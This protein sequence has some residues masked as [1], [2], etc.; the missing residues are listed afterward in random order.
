MEYKDWAFATLIY[1]FQKT[2]FIIVAQIKFLN[3]EVKKKERESTA[4]QST[5]GEFQSLGKMKSDQLKLLEDQ[6]QCE[7]SEKQKLFQDLE[8]LQVKVSFLR[9][10]KIYKL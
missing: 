9:Q 1:S 6:L 3:E 8:D 2:F 10:I 5:I 4:F 7:K